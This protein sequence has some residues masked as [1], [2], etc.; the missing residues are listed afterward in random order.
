MQRCNKIYSHPVYVECMK[1]IA[2]NEQNRIFCLHDLQHSLDTARIGYIYI[3]EHNIKIE[4][5][6][7]YAAALLHD[8]GRYTGIPHNQSGALLAKRIMPDCG[9]SETETST[10]ANAIEAHRNNSDHNEF[11][12]ILYMADKKSRNCHSCKAADECYWSYDKRNADIDI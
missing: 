9:F 4:K 10:V 11:S 3:L 1:R 5:E 8:A 2:D 7:F 12:E 6:L